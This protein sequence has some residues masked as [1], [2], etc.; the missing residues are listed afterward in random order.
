MTRRIL[1]FFFFFFSFP[2][3]LFLLGSPDLPPFPP[4]ETEC[5]GP[6]PFFFLPLPFA[7]S[8]LN[9]PPSFARTGA[10]FPLLF[11]SPPF[12]LLASSISMKARRLFFPWYFVLFFFLFLLFARFPPVRKKWAYNLF[13]FPLFFPM[14]GSLLFFLFPFFF[15]LFFYPLPT[16]LEKGVRL[17]FPFFVFFIV[18]WQKGCLPPFPPPLFFSLFLSMDD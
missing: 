3:F 2:L 12:L 5:A 1:S 14:G 6:S 18:G 16:C 10:F 11:P 13:F 15:L 7:G 17:I 9:S 8:L 4:C